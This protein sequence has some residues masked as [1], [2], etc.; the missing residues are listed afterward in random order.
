MRHQYTVEAFKTKRVRNRSQ[1]SKK[2]KEDQIQ[3]YNFTD[4]QISI[5]LVKKNKKGLGIASAESVWFY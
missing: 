3:E 5:L 4:R 2:K 1:H